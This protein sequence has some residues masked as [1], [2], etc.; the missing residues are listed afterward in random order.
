MQG[1]EVGRQQAGPSVVL[2][3]AGRGSRMGPLTEQIPKALLEVGGRPVWIG[4]WM[5]CSLGRPERLWLC[6]E[7]VL[8]CYPNT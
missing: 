5:Q 6:W 7:M 8:N 4:F 2:L 3:A 1:Y